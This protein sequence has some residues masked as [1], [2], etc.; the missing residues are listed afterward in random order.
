MAVRLK[1]PRQT[2]NTAATAALVLVGLVAAPVFAAPDRALL[3]D[4]T[5]KADLDIAAAELT[6]TPLSNNDEILESHL[7]K[8]RAESAARGAFA[9]QQ[10]ETDD[11][12]VQDTEVADEGAA[13]EPGIRSAS[14]RKV[15][16]YKRQMYR[17]DI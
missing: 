1:E 4:D 2:I 5:A 3:C 9:E 7:L 15:T 8:P 17:R 16:P 10:A 11:A 12:D 13:T 6:A 14:D